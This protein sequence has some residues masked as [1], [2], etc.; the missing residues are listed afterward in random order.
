LQT[1]PDLAALRQAVILLEGEVIL[2]GW[3]AERGGGKARGLGL[4]V[5]TSW[6]VLFVDLDRS[7]TAFPIFKIHAVEGDSL[8]QVTMSAWYDRLQL[9]FDNPAAARAVLNL[10]RQNPSWTASDAIPARQPLSA[11]ENGRAPLQ[12]VAPSND[13]LRAPELARAS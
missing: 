8:C 6:R 11:G 4:L 10:L 2:E 13:V 5:V 3:A 1:P 9:K 12:S 7:F